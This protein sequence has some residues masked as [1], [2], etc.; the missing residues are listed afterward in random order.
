MDATQAREQRDLEQ[1]PIR[2]VDFVDFDLIDKIVGVSTYHPQA[3]T[4]K[5]RARTMSSRLCPF[6]VRAPLRNSPHR[7]DFGRGRES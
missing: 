3:K 2:F 4:K 5:C 7:Q 6:E 1:S